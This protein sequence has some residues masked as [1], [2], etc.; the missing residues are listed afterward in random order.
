[1]KLYLSQHMDYTNADSLTDVDSP[2]T[3]LVV[4]A[5]SAEEAMGKF[6][7]L[8]QQSDLLHRITQNDVATETTIVLLDPILEVMRS[9]GWRIDPPLRAEDYPEVTDRG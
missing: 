9:M 2:A 4:E 8:E 1:M 3:P 7:E 6:F 5:E